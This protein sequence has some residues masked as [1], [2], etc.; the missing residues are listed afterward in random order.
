M[1]IAN[2]KIQ[3]AAYLNRTVASFTV[4]GV[5]LLLGAM[6]DARRAAQR[7]HAFEL[8]RD[9]DIFLSTSA[10]GANWQTGCKTTPGGSTAVLM[11]RVDEVWNYSTSA[12]GVTAYYPRT[13]RIDFGYSGEF[14]R[15]LPVADSQQI[16]YPQDY[17]LS[18]RFAYLVGPKLFVSTTTTATIYK[19][20]GIKWLDD[21]IDADTPDIFL[22]YYTDWFKYATIAALN[23]YLKD[24]ERFAI[25]ATVMGRMWTS[26]INHDG[27]IA[28]A[29]ESISLD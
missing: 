22:T 20:V 8:L 21:L 7:E 16:V 24:S 5:D 13:T 18:R 28:N 26:V 23:V 9:E 17:A 1:T 6:N 15:E 3:I 27:S 14:K 19:L 11:R 25:D 4:G 12:V 2:F 10:A 29:G